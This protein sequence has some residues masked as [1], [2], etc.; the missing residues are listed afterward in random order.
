MAKE[1]HPTYGDIHSEV[2][3]CGGVTRGLVA[4]AQDTVLEFCGAGDGYRVICGGFAM[5]GAGT[6]VICL[7]CLAGCAD[8]RHLHPNRC[9]TSFE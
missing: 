8:P 3:H 7:A 5:T 9:Q 6:N 4:M 2:G 1:V